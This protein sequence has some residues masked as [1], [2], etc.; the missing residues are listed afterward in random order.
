MPADLS[1]AAVDLLDQLARAWHRSGLSLEV[2]LTLANLDDVAI[3]MGETTEISTRVPLIQEL[4][5][6]NLVAVELD[7]DG[8]LHEVSLSLMGRDEHRARQQDA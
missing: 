7:G 5:A 4:A 1:P 6:A 8:A 2:S 3:L